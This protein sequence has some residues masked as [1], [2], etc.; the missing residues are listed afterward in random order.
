MTTPHPH[1]LST[2]ASTMANQSE[3]DTSSKPSWLRPMNKESP[4][5]RHG[6]RTSSANHDHTQPHR[7]PSMPQHEPEP[8]TAAHHTTSTSSYPALTSDSP[9]ACAAKRKVPDEEL[10]DRHPRHIATNL[11]GSGGVG[12]NGRD[13]MW[14][15]EDMGTKIRMRAMTTS[16]IATRRSGGERL[17]TMYIDSDGESSHLLYFCM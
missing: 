8:P 3:R 12:T 6:S 10:R 16:K 9:V 17:R 11:K 1:S 15:D 14:I 5:N 2:T 7:H 4:P 13:T